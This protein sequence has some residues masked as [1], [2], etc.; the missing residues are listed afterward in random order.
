MKIGDLVRRTGLMANDSK[1]NIGLVVR[2]EG[3]TMLIRW[4]EN[5]GTFWTPLHCLEL[6][7]ESR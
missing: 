2:S 7:S 6:L 3:V 5:Y 4:G 1:Q